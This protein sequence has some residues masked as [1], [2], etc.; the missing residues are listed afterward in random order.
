MAWYLD[1]VG[2]IVTQKSHLRRSEVLLSKASQVD[3]GLGL[4]DGLLVN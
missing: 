2:Q 3:K 4:C 1:S